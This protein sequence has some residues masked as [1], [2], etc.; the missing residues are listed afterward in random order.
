MTR[1]RAKIVLL[2][3]DGVLNVD[4]PKGVRALAEL[5]LE[6]SAAAGVALLTKAGYTVLVITNQGAVGRGEMSPAELERINNQ[7]S[8]NIAIAGGHI[9]KFYVCPHRNEDNCAC[10]KP[11]PGLIQQAHADWAF[12]PATTWFLGD[13]SRDVEAA[14]AFGVR[15]AMVLTG[16]GRAESAVH[17]QVPVFADISAFATF[18]TAQESQV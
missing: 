6:P 4:L 2:D 5:Q 3:R 7:I 18:L 12:D 10:R 17:P 14:N 9:T 8:Q 13:A 15:P 1:R 16:K 11:K